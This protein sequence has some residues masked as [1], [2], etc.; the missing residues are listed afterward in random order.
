MCRG[1]FF[2][3]TFGA[4]QPASHSGGLYKWLPSITTTNLLLLQYSILYVLYC[5][6]RTALYSTV[7]QYLLQYYCSLGVENRKSSFTPLLLAS[8]Y[9]YELITAKL[10]H[11]RKP[12]GMID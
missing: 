10:N 7:W 5:T 1:F 12:F 4:N 9:M 3:R 6:R 2:E 11:T 8:S